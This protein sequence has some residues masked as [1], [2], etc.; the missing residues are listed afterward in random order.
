MFQDTFIRFGENVPHVL[1]SIETFSKKNQV[2]FS[3]ET[4]FVAIGHKKPEQVARWLG[5]VHML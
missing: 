3:P 5:E 4:F 1:E 2:L